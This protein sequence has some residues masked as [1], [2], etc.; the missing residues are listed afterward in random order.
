[1]HNRSITA[2]LVLITA[3]AASSAVADS[4]ES[5]TNALWFGSATME[6]AAIPDTPPEV[7]QAS[8]MLSGAAAADSE[9]PAGEHTLANV[10]VPQPA[11]LAVEGTNGWSFV[12]SVDSLAQ[13]E[14]L[15]RM[16]NLLLRTEIRSSPFSFGVDDEVRFI[17]RR[18][19]RPSISAPLGVAYQMQPQATR[20]FAEFTPIIDESLGWGG[21]LGIRLFFR[22]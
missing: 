1:M 17:E 5:D 13:R 16:L 7:A 12:D 4:S 22:R 3:S 11:K 21:G 18:D 2:L 19:N 9:E 8:P 6:V 15:F 20:L 10:D 14:T